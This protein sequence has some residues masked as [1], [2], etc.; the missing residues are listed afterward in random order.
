MHHHAACQL[1]VERPHAQ[2]APRRDADQ[3]ERFRQHLVERFAAAGPA[4][5]AE[6][7]RLELG[8]AQLVEFALP[9]ADARDHQGPMRQASLPGHAD[10]RHDGVLHAGP[11]AIGRRSGADDLLGGG[12]LFGDLFG[13]GIHGFSAPG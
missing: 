3:A 2:H 10:E 13:D 12:G 1:H 8:V 5:E 11:E 4:A 9:I 7:G 6:P